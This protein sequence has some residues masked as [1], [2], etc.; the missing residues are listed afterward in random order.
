MGSSGS[1]VKGDVVNTQISYT[2]G[3]VVCPKF[4]ISPG[5]AY[6]PAGTGVVVKGIGSVQ[7]DIR[8]SGAAQVRCEV[9]IARVESDRTGDAGSVGGM[10]NILCISRFTDSKPGHGLAVFVPSEPI[11]I[12]AA[13]KGG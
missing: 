1:R 8:G 7:T 12:Y 3:I 2:T 9:N 13:P 11:R 6:R 5:R 4:D 10:I